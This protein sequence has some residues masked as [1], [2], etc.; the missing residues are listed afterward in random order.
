M[1]ECS[2]CRRFRREGTF[3]VVPIT[4]DQPFGRIGIDLVGPF[5][6]STAGMRCIIIVTDYATRYVEAKPSKEKSAMTVAKFLLKEIF[7]KHGAPQ[8]IICD[9]GTPNSGTD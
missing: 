5:R 4:I 8:E 9:Q 7:L 3:K 1:K 2:T 6:N